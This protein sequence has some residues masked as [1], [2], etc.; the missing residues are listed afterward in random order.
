MPCTGPVG[1]SEIGGDADQSDVH[2]REVVRQRCAH[3][4][5]NLSVAR[6][7]HRIVVIRGGGT[8]GCGVFCVHRDLSSFNCS[9]VNPLVDGPKIPIMAIPTSIAPPMNTATAGT[10]PLCSSEPMTRPDNAA[11]M[12]LHEYTK[13]TARE[14]I[15]VGN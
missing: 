7:L 12:W 1:D 6:L 13:P 4:R 11:A 9:S 14:R 3:E 8:G 10:P 2:V 15:R 5:G